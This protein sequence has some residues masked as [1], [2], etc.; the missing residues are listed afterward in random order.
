M[1]FS[2]RTPS[3]FSVTKRTF[4]GRTWGLRAL[5]AGKV[6]AVA[7]ELIFRRHGGG[8]TWLNTGTGKIAVD[9][10]RWAWHLPPHVVWSI[11]AA[12]GLWTAVWWGAARYRH[13]RRPSVPFMVILTYL[14]IAAATLWP[15]IGRSG[16]AVDRPLYPEDWLLRGGILLI[17][18]GGLLAWGSAPGRQLLDITGAP[19]SAVGFLRGSQLPQRL[20]GV[21]LMTL[22]GF[23]IFGLLLPVILHPHHPVQGPAP[24]PSPELRVYWGLGLCLVYL[25][26]RSMWRKTWRAMQPVS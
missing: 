10:H 15:K 22:A 24:Q 23:A 4:P 17:G 3:Q 14:F 5:A 19:R 16:A 2:G 25:L 9:L 12:V 11:C 13:W 20:T 8:L 21:G 26:G 1:R 18:A 6:C 7:G